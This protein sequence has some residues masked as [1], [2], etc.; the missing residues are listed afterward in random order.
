MDSPGQTG[1]PEDL[2]PRAPLSAAIIAYNE[3]RNLP[4]CLASIRWVDEVVIVVDPRSDDDTEKIARA[5][6]A[7][8]LLREYPGDIEQKSFCVDRVSHEWVLIV[9][10]DE[11]VTPGLARE[12]RE[13]LRVAP[14]GPAGYE[15]NRITWHLGR[16]IRHGDF[17]PDWTLRLF[18]RSAARWVGMNPHGRIL[19]D[20]GVARLRGELEHYSYWDLADQIDRIQNFSEQSA[21]ALQRS[22]RSAGFGRLVLRP[23]LRFVRSYV[24]K[25]GFLD[26]WPGFIIAAASAFH[27]FLKYAKLYERR[28]GAG[29]AQRRRP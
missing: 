16:W 19:V 9:D 27:V 1:D 12:I 29:N 3:A 28:L 4:R 8:V 15:I 23:P 14:D 2:E 13:V 11:V 26:G 18:R 7:R 20:G 10:P 6:G 21:R 22:G 17:Y 24:L 5:S 25:R